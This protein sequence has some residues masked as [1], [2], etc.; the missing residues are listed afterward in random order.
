M[1]LGLTQLLAEMNTRKYV[2]EFKCCRRIS[3]TT[4]PPSVSR[5]SREDWILD[6]PQLYGPP[7]PV[8]VIALLYT[9]LLMNARDNQGGRLLSRR[10]TVT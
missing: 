10:K 6:I 3:Q 7:R 1:A 5:L 8:T 9:F 2:W 4:S